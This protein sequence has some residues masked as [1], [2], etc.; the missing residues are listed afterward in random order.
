MSLK[1]RIEKEGVRKNWKNLSKRKSKTGCKE[2][3]QEEK[4]KDER[5][6]INCVNEWG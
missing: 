6:E 1:E 2:S 4:R 3:E 5:N